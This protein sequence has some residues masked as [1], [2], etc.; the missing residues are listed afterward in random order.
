MDSLS[1]FSILLDPHPMHRKQVEMK[2]V[3]NKKF[4]FVTLLV[5]HVLIFYYKYQN[6]NG[7]VRKM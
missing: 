7:L 1:E 3:N 4:G 6:R 5:F 2:T